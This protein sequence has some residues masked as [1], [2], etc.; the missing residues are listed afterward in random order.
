MEEGGVYQALCLC[1]HPAW[2]WARGIYP[3]TRPVAT[4]PVWKL[5]IVT[6][7]IGL[8]NVHA[9]TW[10]S[11]LTDSP[12]LQPRRSACEH[13]LPLFPSLGSGL[14]TAYN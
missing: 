4:R 12:F 5:L 3:A 14:I 6:S 8:D 10:F 13:M 2:D 1:L 7:F 9:Q 11:A